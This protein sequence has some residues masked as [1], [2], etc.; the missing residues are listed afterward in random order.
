[1]QVAGALMKLSKSKVE[2][3]PKSADTQISEMLEE[4]FSKFDPDRVI[5][6]N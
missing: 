6:E 3:A 1:M 2:V 4:A 5:T